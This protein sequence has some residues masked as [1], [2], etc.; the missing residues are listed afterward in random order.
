MV[1]DLA[2]R[3]HITAGVALASAVVIAAGPM[4]QHLPHLHLAQQLRQVSVSDINLTDAASGMTDLFSGV[5]NELESLASG[6]SALAVPAAALTDFINPAALPL[7]VQTWVTTFQALGMNT[8]QIFDAWTQMP[9]P[10]AQQIAANWL[11][12][13]SDYVGPFQTVANNMVNYFTGTQTS[14]FVPLLQQAWSALINTSSSTN[15]TQAFNDLNFAFIINPAIQFGE[16]LE[17]VLAIPTYIAAN[18]SSFVNGLLNTGNGLPFTAIGY[19]VASLEPL[20]EKT[21]AGA[22]QASFNAFNVGDATDGVLNLVNIPGA[23][24]NALL[25]GQFNNTKTIQGWA[26]GLLSFATCRAGTCSPSGL[27]SKLLLNFSPNLASTMVAPN[28]QNIAQGGSLVTAFQNF[29]NQ[30]INGWPSLSPVVSDISGGLTSLL[31]SIPS[32]LSNLPSMLGNL[33]GAL[34]GQIGAW[35][36]TILRLL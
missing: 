21:F 5:G 10:V 3:P 33:G 15:I 8:Q 24:I 6:A 26:N 9:F 1:V 31:Q 28:G 36:A 11:Q 35:I 34:T 23:M 20:L 17:N 29:A 16:P 12:Y 30:L 4:A 27:L 25:N 22:L 13:G 7:P 14:D 18:F 32:T 19:F 2:A